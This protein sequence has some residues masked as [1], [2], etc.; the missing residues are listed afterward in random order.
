[1]EPP[2]HNDF[3]YRRVTAPVTMDRAEELLTASADGTTCLHL[4]ATVGGFKFIPSELLNSKNLLLP[5]RR[6]DTPLHLAAFTGRLRDLPI[7]SLTTQTL[8]IKDGDGMTVID[9][10]KEKQHLDQLPHDLLRTLPFYKRELVLSYLKKKSPHDIPEDCLSSDLWAQRS[11]DISDKGTLYHEAA[12]SGVLDLLPN[13]LFCPNSL[14]LRDDRG[15]TPV[16]L[17]ATHAAP[18]G[19]ARIASKIGAELQWELVD[20][21]EDTILHAAANGCQLSAV[22][23]HLMNDEHLRRRNDDQK[24]VVD[25][26]HQHGGID[27]I[28]EPLR[29]L[30]IPYTQERIRHALTTGE[31]DG[32][33]PSY[34]TK[35]PLE[36]FLPGGRSELSA[37]Q[38]VRK[39]GTY[40]LLDPELLAEIAKEALSGTGHNPLHAA[41]AAGMLSELPSNLLTLDLLK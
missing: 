14:L 40:H 28:P 15:R 8:E 5:D 26:A 41:A 23:A 27:A 20:E 11:K 34:F 21:N 36:R 16:H 1:M 24:N 31:A 6:G 30:S 13:E 7:S 37:L 38:L 12:R 2:L 25:L 19:L 33:P 22:P 9:I 18:E 10:A 32:I 35:E 17:V 29:F 3:R 4:A 39:N